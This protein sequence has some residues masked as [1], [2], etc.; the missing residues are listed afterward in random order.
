M[1]VNI[2]TRGRPEALQNRRHTMAYELPSFVDPVRPDPVG[3][4]VRDLM[5]PPGPRGSVDLDQQNACGA[6]APGTVLR[7]G[8]VPVPGFRHRADGDFCAAAT[9]R[10]LSKG[11]LK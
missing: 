5:E 1:N 2:A 9:T 7:V 6:I 8:I 11:A 10:R 3:P 4:R